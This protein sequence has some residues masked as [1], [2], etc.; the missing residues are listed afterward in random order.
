MRLCHRVLPFQLLLDCYKQTYLPKH[1]QEPLYMA[2]CLKSM[3][4]IPRER[5]LIPPMYTTINHAEYIHPFPSLLKNILLLK[6]Y[7]LI[8]LDSLIF[9]F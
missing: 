1:Y 7:I 6:D 4:E 2:T 9:S 5:W 8:N 3:E